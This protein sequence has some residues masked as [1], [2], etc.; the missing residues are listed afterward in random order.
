MLLVIDN[1][2]SFTYNLVQYCGHLGASVCV[3]RNDVSLS[4]LR[5]LRPEAV[6]VSPGPCTPDD[7][8]VSL[9]AIGYFSGRIPVLGVCLGHQALGQAFGATVTRAKSLMHGK[10]SLVTHVDDPLFTDVPNP[11]QATRYHSLIVDRASLPD[12]FEVTAECDDV[13]MAL[14]HKPTGAA[15]VQFHPESILTP[16]GQLILRNF[17]RDT[18]GTAEVGQPRLQDDGAQFAAAAAGEGYQ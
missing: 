16:D 7:A 5:A 6:I 17:L 15:G 9:D 18:V 12:T 4:S 3:R 10:T 13:I 11:F 14:R 1:F 2:D 8:G